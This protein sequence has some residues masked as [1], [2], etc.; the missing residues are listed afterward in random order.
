MED[1]GKLLLRGSL[2]SISEATILGLNW[3]GLRYGLKE[4]PVL[5]GN[6]QAGPAE[7]PRKLGPAF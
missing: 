3:V 4:G 5:L 2:I 6:S 7:V 1:Q